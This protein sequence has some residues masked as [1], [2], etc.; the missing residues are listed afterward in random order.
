MRQTSK[1]KN[2]NYKILQEN[3]EKLNIDF[4]NNFLDRRTKYIHQ[5]K[6]YMNW[7]I[8]KFKTSAHQRTQ[9]TE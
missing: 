1:R 8:A 2:Q 5:M 6:I 3:R 9:L 7:I 4:D